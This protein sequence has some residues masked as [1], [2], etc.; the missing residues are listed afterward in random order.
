MLLCF[1]VIMRQSTVQL[2]LYDI[3]I[4]RVHQKLFTENHQQVQTV[5]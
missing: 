1:D 3:R 2:G 5:L 4:M